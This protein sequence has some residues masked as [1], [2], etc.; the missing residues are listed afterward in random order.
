MSG[1]E[2]IAELQGRQVEAHYLLGKS[3]QEIIKEEGRW[4]KYSKIHS[5]WIRGNEKIFKKGGLTRNRNGLFIS[6]NDWFYIS[7]SKASLI[8]KN[9]LDKNFPEEKMEEVKSLAEIN[10]LQML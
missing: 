8:G 5:A 6:A 7:T 4:V 1:L 10:K 3:V 9:A 2:W